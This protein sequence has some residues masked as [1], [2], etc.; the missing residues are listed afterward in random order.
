MFLRILMLAILILAVGRF[1]AWLFA[2]R[3]GGLGW[4]RPSAAVRRP[5]AAPR[6]DRLRRCATCGV[7]L[8]EEG[9]IAHA[10]AFYCCPAHAPFGKES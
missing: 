10:D 5:G 3:P 4:R 6:L 9:G 1:L 8:P 2:V 7:F